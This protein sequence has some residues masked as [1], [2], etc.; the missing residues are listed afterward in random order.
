[1]SASVRMAAVAVS[2]HIHN[3]LSTGVPTSVCTSAWESG[4]YVGRLGQPRG[5]GFIGARNQ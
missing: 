4:E 5:V 3:W 2:K 1:M